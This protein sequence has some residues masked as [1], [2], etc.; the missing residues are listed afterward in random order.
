ESEVIEW[1]A[2]RDNA[3]KVKE[4]LESNYPKVDN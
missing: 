2:G 4:V 1:L 3:D